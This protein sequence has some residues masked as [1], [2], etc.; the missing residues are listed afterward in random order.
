[1]KTFLQRWVVTTLA[2]LVAANLVSGIHYD[3]VSG[4]L[5]ASLLLGIL[6]AFLR[7]LMML[8]TLPLVIL[9]LGLF[10][11]VINAVLLYLVGWLVKSFRVDSF[12]AAFWGGLVISLVSLLVNSLVGSGES[13]IQFRRTKRPPPGRDNHSGG[14]PVIDV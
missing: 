2:V 8:L 5:A 1:V 4:L 6:N 11:L 10:M 12:G 14:G 7:P 9:S 13:R 3:T